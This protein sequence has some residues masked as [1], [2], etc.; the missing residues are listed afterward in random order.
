M[1]KSRDR[2]HL[3]RVWPIWP[4]GA[5]WT[6]AFCVVAPAGCT[7]EKPP[8]VAVTNPARESLRF[9]ENKGAYV[10]QFGYGYGDDVLFYVALGPSHV[11]PNGMIMDEIVERLRIFG[12][13]SLDLRDSSINDDGLKHL[14]EQLE[15][16]GLNL[17]DRPIT[18]DG[19]RCLCEMTEL[20]DLDLCGTLTTDE[21]VLHLT[22]LALLQTINLT[23]TEISAA[24]CTQLAAALPMCEIEQ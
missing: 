13:V 11:T 20:K 17:R 16:E 9:L 1:L 14:S 21:A 10:R 2:F 23:G 4:R 15:L 24:G 19:V 8:P 6:L 7:Q 12:R 18:D 3:L 22:Q 5:F